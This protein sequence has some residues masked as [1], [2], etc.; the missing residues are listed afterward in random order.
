MAVARFHT[1]AAMKA[2]FSF[3]D[4]LPTR[5]RAV[6]AASDLN[7]TKTC[8]DQ[9][10][11]VAH[12]ANRRDGLHQMNATER[13]EKGVRD[14]LKIP[15]VLRVDLIREEQGVVIICAWW[16][17]PRTPRKSGRHS[18]S[19]RQAAMFVFH[20]T[21]PR[22]AETGERRSRGVPGGRFSARVSPV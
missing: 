10:D 13:L 11:N 17:A 8:V 3:S 7:G 22:P 20:N 15:A 14:N 1:S 21:T 5:R 18:P 19:A 2:R 6:D 9:A 4:V 12:Q 16:E